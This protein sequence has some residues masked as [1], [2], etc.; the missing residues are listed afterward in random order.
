MQGT[1]RGLRP[2]LLALATGLVI[3][4]CQNAPTVAPT[5][6]GSGGTPSGAPPSTAPSPSEAAVDV[7]PLFVEAIKNLDSG[8]VALDGSATVGPI[9]VDIS[10]TTT[11]DGPDSK[12]K[13]TTTVA[14]VATVNETVHVAGKSYA[15][16]GNGPWLESPPSSGCD[17]ST[18]LKDASPSSFTD[19]GT[20]T[21]NGATVHQLESS[22][23]GAFDPAVFLCSSPGV[24]NVTGSTTF[25]CTD[26]GTPVGAT[27]ELTYTQTVGAQALDGSLTFEISFSSIG[28]SQSIS[29]PDSVWARFNVDKRGYSIAHPANYDHTAR[30][31]FDYFVGPDDSF[32][33]G[34]R[35]ATQGYTLNAIAKSEISSAKSSL[36]AKAVT[37]EDV[38]VG[39]VAG[40][41]LNANGS[42]ADL[43]GKVVFF[44][45]IVVKGKYAYFVAWVSHAGNEAADLATFMQVLST[46]QFLA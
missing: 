24:S 37:N 29:A 12:G 42:S 16:S 6:G 38:V 23:S 21:R 9:K 45:A 13:T 15:K 22:G 17:L 2:T 27:I 33:F 4:A 44:E 5:P 40:R 39:G 10:G 20:T 32:Y 3:A 1:G 11:F 28:S 30:Q 18:S 26:D 31:G 8:I 7:A 19:K 34:S 35:V 25:Y 43:G 46:F 14:G 36:N 41:L